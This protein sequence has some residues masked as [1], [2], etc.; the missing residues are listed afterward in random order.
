MY[1]SQNRWNNLPDKRKKYHEHENKRFIWLE[2][3]NRWQEIQLK[4]VEITPLYGELTVNIPWEGSCTKKPWEYQVT[5]VV[6]CLN[7]SET[8]PVCIDLLRLQTIKPFIMII[9][10]GSQK[11][12]LEKVLEMRDEDVE[13]HSIALNGVL[14][15]SDYPAMAMDLAMTLCRTPY[16]FATHADVFLKKQDFIEYLLTEC[17]EEVPVVGY[18]ISPRS[19]SDWHGMISHTASMYNIKIM[20]K[21]GFAW[22]LRKLCNEY[23]IVNYKPDPMRP[24]WPDTEI[25]GNYILR[26]NNIKTKI[27][28]HEENQQRTNDDYIDHFRSYTSGKMY[29]PPYFQKTKLWFED[30]MEKAL[31]RINE[32]SNHK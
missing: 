2:S 13:V 4:N 12:H 26:K 16:L 21:I 28:G 31:T 20:D 10:T 32:W 1:I 15:P 17:N 9:D 27:I 14:H 30:A 23:N 7:T 3:E 11:E 22:S 24:N 8:L 19:H 25:L 18:E 5:A 29:S 6:P